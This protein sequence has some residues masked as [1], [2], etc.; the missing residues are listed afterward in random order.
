[1]PRRWSTAGRCAAR[2]PKGVYAVVG[3]DLDYQSAKVNIIAPSPEGVTNPPTPNFGKPPIVFATDSSVYRPAAYAMLELEPRKGLRIV[4]STRVDYTREGKTWNVS[5]RMSP[6]VFTL[7]EGTT[8]KGGVGLFYQPGLP[9]R[10]I[11]L[12]ERRAAQRPG[13]A[14][15]PRAR[16]GPRQGRQENLRRGVPQG[17]QQ[18]DSLGARGRADAFRHAIHRQ[19]RERPGVRGEFLLKLRHARF[20]GW[21]AYTLSRSTRIDGPSKV[22]RLFE[23][24]R[25]HPAAVASYTLGRGWEA[26]ARFR[27]VLPETHIHLMW[28]ASLILTPAHMER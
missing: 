11:R 6:D 23:Y 13:V 19:H 7:A 2:W 15:E 27:Y 1:M 21:I 16:A 17:A 10:T 5:P 28:V 25:W 12:R 4:P 9:Q 8:L 22:E 24:D 20:T 3:L 18:L 26:G 14:P